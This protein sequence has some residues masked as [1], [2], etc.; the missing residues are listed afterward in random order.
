MDGPE[1]QCSRWATLIGHCSAVARQTLSD[2][3]IATSRA[4]ARNLAELLSGTEREEN[5]HMLVTH[6]LLRLAPE[7]R[8]EEMQH[9][10]QGELAELARHARKVKQRSGY[11]LRATALWTVHEDR[12]LRSF[13][14]DVISAPVRSRRRL[15]KYNPRDLREECKDRTSMR[16][17]EDS[18]WE[19]WSG[20]IS[21][22]A[23]SSPSHYEKVR[24]MIER[25]DTRKELQYLFG[26]HRWGTIKSHAVRIRREL[27]LDPTIFPFKEANLSEHLDKLLTENVS[28]S[29]PLNFILSVN[30]MAGMLGGKSFALEAK[31]K[32]IRRAL[33]I[34]LFQE[35]AKALEPDLE[36]VVALETAG[37]SAE[38]ETIGYIYDCFRLALGV[39]GR[40]DDIQHIGEHTLE[41]KERSIEFTAWQ[42]KVTDATASRTQLL[43]LTCPKRSIAGQQDGETW[44]DRFLRRHRE[45]RKNPSLAE[46]DHLVPAVANGRNAFKRQPMRR[47][48]ALRLVREALFSRGIEKERTLKFTLPS[49]RV[50]MPSLS[51]RYKID[52]S[53]RSALGRWAGED[54]ADIY[55]RKLSETVIRVWDETFQAVNSQGYENN[56]NMKNIDITGDDYGLGPAPSTKIES[57]HCKRPHSESSDTGA[58]TCKCSCTCGTHR[59]GSE[60]ETC[61]LLG[62]HNTHVGPCCFKKSQNY[63]AYDES[64]RHKASSFQVLFQEDPLRSDP[65]RVGCNLECEVK[66]AHIFNA[67]NKTIGCSWRPKDLS[68]ITWVSNRQDWQDIHMMLH[69]ACDK[70][71]SK[72]RMPLDWEQIGNADPTDGTPTVPASPHSPSEH[73]TSASSSDSSSSS[74]SQKGR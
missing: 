25:R 44:W 9:S 20:W 6:A 47:G 28:P 65:I 64:K 46:R 73:K 26:N 74:A 39:S 32:R 3:G 45:L 69:K 34:N 68:R 50:W 72:H 4:D 21:D 48:Q 19:E 15:R 17:L 52:K 71:F 53:S 55:R 58:A 33:T 56:E 43:P 2:F 22:L 59:K 5:L 54:S 61:I 18:L 62:P 7:D 35:S 38:N 57:G 70:C 42:T 66:K 24:K 11:P 13:S 41:D 27:R 37:A 60:R 51:Y 67:Q 12:L 36:M 23:R 1:P 49:L 63:N 40:W 8:T 29:R 10:L 30:W 31:A 16:A 14:N